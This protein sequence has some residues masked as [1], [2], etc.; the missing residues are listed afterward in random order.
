MKPF[1]Q[2]TQPPQSLDD[3]L[4]SIATQEPMT[5]ER[6]KMTYD[7]NLWLQK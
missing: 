6:L 3:L 5:P 4:K 2:K 7:E 1:F